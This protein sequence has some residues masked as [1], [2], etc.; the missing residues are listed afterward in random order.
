[1][2]KRHALSVHLDTQTHLS[3]CW[4]CGFD[5]LMHIG[6]TC[7]PI[8]HNTFASSNS[9]PT[10]AN[11]LRKVDCS[12]A[13]H[14][15]HQILTTPAT[16]NPRITCSMRASAQ[17]AP[18]VWIRDAITHHIS[19]A[20][21]RAWTARAPTPVPNT[22]PSFSKALRTLIACTRRTPS[23]RPAS[24]MSDSVCVRWTNTFYRCNQRGCS[25]GTWVTEQFKLFPD[26]PYRHYFYGVL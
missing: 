24:G 9:L 12:A 17:S 22:R 4:R 19:R 1:M 16:S 8:L 25:S 20:H 2:E 10:R 14:T 21:T 18:A 23:V 6:L 26:M 15:N 11:T 13:A 7:A 5:H 3:L